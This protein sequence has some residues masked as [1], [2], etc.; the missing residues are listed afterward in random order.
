MQAGEISNPIL[1]SAGFHLFY[2]KDLQVGS[3]F[4]SY[5]EMKQE[6]YREML[7]S[8]MQRQERVFLEEVRRKAVINR[9]L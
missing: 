8:A 6:L 4:P 9:M 5:D 2:V 7:D 3:N 1:G